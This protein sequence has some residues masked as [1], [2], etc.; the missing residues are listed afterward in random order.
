MNFTVKKQT[1]YI[2]A[3]NKSVI[4]K[5]FSYLIYEIWAKFILKFKRE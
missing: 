4:D 1:I 2:L 5:L 3:V